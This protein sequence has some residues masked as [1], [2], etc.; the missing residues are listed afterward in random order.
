MLRTALVGG[1]VSLSIVALIAAGLFLRSLGSAK[2]LDPGFESR[3][4]A[5]VTLRPAQQAHDRARAEQFCA[6]VLE[7]ARS[8][9][10][11]RSASLATTLP[12]FGGFAR[13]V[14]LEGQPQE[15]GKGV[16]VNTNNVDPGYFQTLGVPFVRG[17]DFTE[18]DRAGTR[19][20][21]NVNETM[22][23]SE[24]RRVGEEG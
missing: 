3:R 21:A 4:L 1:Q 10:G 23:R 5:L 14:F 2:D 17:R 13:S 22:A 7:T 8:L 16:L 24:E 6:G 19:P 20:V 18:M 15:K 9:P 12:L 11:V